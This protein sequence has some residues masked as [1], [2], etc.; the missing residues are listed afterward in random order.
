M[1]A[2]RNRVC[3][4]T[5]DAICECSDER[6]S[7]PLKSAAVTLHTL[8]PRPRSKDSGCDCR[9]SSK[10]SLAATPK[11]RVK[12][13]FSRFVESIYPIRELACTAAFGRTASCAASR[14]AR[15]ILSQNAIH[16][17]LPAFPS[18]PEVLKHLRTVSH[19]NKRLCLFGLWSTAQYSHRNHFFQLLRRQR[20]CI[21][22]CPRR[23]RNCPV[24]SYC[25][26]R[27][28]NSFRLF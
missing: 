7:P 25:G 20:L 1:E 18:G 26:H 14:M 2:S 9:A 22:I 12:L 27:D 4:T 10:A 5:S 21:G 8:P 16:A 19:R 24:F 23:S 11:V 15:N 28:G 17:R 6:I 13:F 3:R